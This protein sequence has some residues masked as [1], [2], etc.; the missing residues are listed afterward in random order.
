[1]TRRNH[2]KRLDPEYYRGDAIVHWSTTISGRQTGWLNGISYYRFR[3]LLAHTAFRYGIAS[4]I[5]CL[6]P[7]HFHMVWMGLFTESNQL[8]AMK[9]FRKTVNESLHRIGFDLQD[10]AYDHV[11][12]NDERREEGLLAICDYVARNP[13]RKRLVEPDGYRT[14]QY[15]GCLVPGYPQLRP[16]EDGFWDEL[17]RVMAYLKKNGLFRR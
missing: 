1:M 5:F 9:H 3:E 6:M 17:N 8:L 16:F 14:Y 11:L 10:Q 4:P 7:D 2:L 13:E 15:T 12:Q